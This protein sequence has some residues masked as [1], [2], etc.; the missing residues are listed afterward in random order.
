[1]EYTVRKTGF[2]A[3]T[4]YK[5]GKKSIQ[6]YSEKEQFEI[7]YEDIKSVRLK[8]API[9][10]ESNRFECVIKSG[11]DKIS[12]VSVNFERVF[13]FKIQSEEYVSFINCLHRKL[14]DYKNIQYYSGLTPFRYSLSVMIVVLA[15]LTII[16]LI[17]YFTEI[18]N[19]FY[20]VAK[21]I[22]ILSLFLVLLLYIKKNKPQNYEPLKL[23]KNLMP[24]IN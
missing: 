1:L 6:V 2:N 18:V 23:P 21:F 10:V 20:F 15:P 5:L 3:K 7:L 13:E 4:S 14:Q 16:G 24:K 19:S 9:K 17:V 11:K 22:G 8:Y 12:I